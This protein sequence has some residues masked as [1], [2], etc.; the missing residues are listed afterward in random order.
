M[1]DI[2][3]RFLSALEREVAARY[4]AETFTQCA[5]LLASLKEMAHQPLPEGEL[6]IP[7]AEA[8]GRSFHAAATPVSD[9]VRAVFAVGCTL[10][11]V[12]EQTGELS[13]G[14][15]RRLQTLVG[16]A[17]A[18]VAGSFERAQKIR[19]DAWLSFLTHELKNPLNT[20]LNSLWLI[21]EKGGI[22]GRATRFVEMAERAARRLEGHVREVRALEERLSGLPP[23]WE[24]RSAG[25][26]KEP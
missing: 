23:G 26:P 4:G 10:V 20:L 21:R 19:R 24:K 9:A 12:G 1:S 2:D 22:D 6:E 11:E 14:E 7:A 16:E 18:Q 17:A 8:L 13:V 25:I 15:A 5:A 3:G